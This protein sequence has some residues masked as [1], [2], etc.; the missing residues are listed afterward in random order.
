MITDETRINIERFDIFYQCF[1]REYPCLYN[2][3]SAKDCAN[4][5]LFDIKRA[6]SPYGLCVQG[7]NPWTN[8]I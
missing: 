8:I 4:Y 1:I 7:L 2:L 6:G 5:M 3:V